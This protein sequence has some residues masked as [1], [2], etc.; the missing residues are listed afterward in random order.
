MYQGKQLSSLLHRYLFIYTCIIM[1]RKERNQIILQL[2]RPE[3]NGVGRKIGNNFLCAV[4][5]INSISR[6]PFTLEKLGRNGY[7]GAIRTWRKGRAVTSTRVLTKPVAHLLCA[8]QISY[9]AAV[10]SARTLGLEQSTATCII[11][12]F[13]NTSACYMQFSTS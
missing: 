5:S 11:P 6:V 3:R 4:S 7:S 8:S 1:I 12:E 9:L 13:L 2:K 10:A